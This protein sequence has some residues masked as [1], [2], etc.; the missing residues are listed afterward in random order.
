MEEAEK[1]Q[2]RTKRAPAK[3]RHRILLT[4]KQVAPTRRREQ[5]WK[6]RQ[7]KS[8]QEM[9]MRQR[10]Y[11]PERE[12]ISRKSTT[13]R[14]TAERGSKMARQLKDGAAA[15]VIDLLF[16]FGTFYLNPHNNW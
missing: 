13:R 15:D 2:K 9:K 1:A 7:R 11:K 14:C 6:E 5:W 4:K 12:E 8:R 10:R 16:C 3:L